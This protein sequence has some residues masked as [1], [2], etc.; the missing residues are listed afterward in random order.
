MTDVDDE[1]YEVYRR[2]ATTHY[3]EHLEREILY[4]G[5]GHV[6]W[7]KSRLPETPFWMRGATELSAEPEG[8]AKQRRLDRADDK[9]HER[10]GDRLVPIDPDDPWS[11]VGWRPGAS[12]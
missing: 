12:S 5:G 7:G 6:T 8:A 2:P 11:E 9:T 4:P 10:A 3:V 1:G